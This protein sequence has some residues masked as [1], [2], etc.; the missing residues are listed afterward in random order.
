M[1]LV[2]SAMLKLVCTGMQLPSLVFKLFNSPGMF[3]EER[4]FLNVLLRVTD[5]KNTL[6]RHAEEGAKLVKAAEVLTQSLY[7]MKVGH[8]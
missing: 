6:L 2:D 8:K 4:Y 7:D 1:I 5:S 3:V